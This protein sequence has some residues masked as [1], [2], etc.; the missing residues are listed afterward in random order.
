MI[1]HL[2]IRRPSRAGRLT[3]TPLQRARTTGNGAKSPA[4]NPSPTRSAPPT[5]VVGRA[6]TATTDGPQRVTPAIKPSRMCCR[7]TGVRRA[8]WELTAVAGPGLA[9]SGRVRTDY[10]QLTQ[11]TPRQKPVRRP[12]SPAMDPTVQV[13]RFPLG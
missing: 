7:Q 12:T 9:G 4:S 6:R 1:I 10:T 13:T 11:P 2:L 3:S 8:I 5:V